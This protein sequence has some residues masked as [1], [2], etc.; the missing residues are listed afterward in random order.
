V[1]VSE[2]DAADLANPVWHALRGPQAGFAQANASGRA[3]RFDPEVCPFG[4]VGPL[5]DKAWMEQADL[6]GSQGFAVLFREAVPPV[7]AG[8]EEVLRLPGLQMIA[9]ELPPAPDLPVVD[10]GPEDVPEMLELT[11]TTEPGPFLPRTVEMGRYLG[12][13]RDGRLVAMAGERLRIRGFT[14]VSAVCT[15]PD[16]QRQGLGAAMT[17]HVAAGIRE[18]GD[19]VFLHVL[20]ENDNAIRLYRALGFR[21]RRKIDAVAAQWIGAAAA[22]DEQAD[23]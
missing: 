2:T 1:T 13:R 17:L 4:A 23:R 8:W 6:V 16:A 9:G 10:L 18:R 14:E 21:I 5:D 7:P 15:H 20:A 3:L 19:R 22:P 11:Q 12:I